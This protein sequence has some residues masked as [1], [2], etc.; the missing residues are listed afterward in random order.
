LGDGGVVA[1]NSLSEISPIYIPAD[2]SGVERKNHTI[3]AAGRVL[4]RLAVQIANLLR[5]KQKPNF[6]SYLDMGDFVTVKNLKNIKITGK[7]IEQ[8][9]YYRHSK[10]PG[11][12]KEIPLKRLM[13]KDPQEVLKK[14]VWGMLPIN[15][16]RKEQIKRLKME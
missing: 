11:G 13:E 9:K 4:G 16:L 7:K 15:K 5:G 14:A 2:F 12:F 10:Y 8:K 6:V 1:K 3:D